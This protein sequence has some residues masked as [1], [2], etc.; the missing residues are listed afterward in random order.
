MQST[1]QTAVKRVA[2]WGLGFIYAAVWAIAGWLWTSPLNDLDYFFFPAVRIALSG[3]PLMVYA[4][5][6]K[7]VIANDNGPFSLLPLTAVA[8]VASRLGLL[9]DE[10]LRRMLVP[11]ALSFFTPFIGR[12]AAS[13]I[14][15]LR[16]AHL[17]G[18]VP[19]AA[20]RLFSVPP[21]PMIQVLR[22]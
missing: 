7:E 13:V 12:G 9:D 3:H 17:L 18:I 6:Y 1:K 20:Y 8:A 15:G 21:N 11:A 19:L 10:R 14:S 4:A 2:T 22:S 5:R 16:G